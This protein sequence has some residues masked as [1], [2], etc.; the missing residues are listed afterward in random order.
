MSFEK[1][2]KN[3]YS[4]Q[5][6]WTIDGNTACGG[7]IY[8]SDV[9]ITAAHCCALF[10]QVDYSFHEIIA[11]ELSPTLNFGGQRSGI[12]FHLTHPDYNAQTFENDVC[13]LYLESDFD[14]NDKKVA[15][16]PLNKQSLPNSG[17]SCVVSG[18]GT[19]TVMNF[20]CVQKFEFD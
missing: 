13:L 5:V 6:L 8:S 9:I 1:T 4:M 15:A 14:F 19:T 16:I 12:K 17:K 11:G 10:S 20:S 2:P 7:S 3:E 18:W